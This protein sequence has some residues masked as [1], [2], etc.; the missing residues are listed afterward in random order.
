M[1]RHR[2]F[3]V[4]SFDVETY[5][6]S[7]KYLARYHL[8]RTMRDLIKIYK[9]D[10]DVESIPPDSLTPDWYVSRYLEHRASGHWLQTNRVVHHSDVDTDLEKNTGGTLKEGRVHKPRHV[11]SAEI[12]S[13]FLMHAQ[14]LI[15]DQTQIRRSRTRVIDVKSWTRWLAKGR[16]WRA[17]ALEENPDLHFGMFDSED[18]DEDVDY[19]SIVSDEE[20]EPPEVPIAPPQPLRK[21][22]HKRKK[23]PVSLWS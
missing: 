7:C 12:R 17:E 14:W 9:E 10:M 6:L 2:A 19:M 3:K 11:S 4:L 1:I 18:E 16:K 23:A 21:I 8:L 20:E 13:L 22:S 5:M 15:H